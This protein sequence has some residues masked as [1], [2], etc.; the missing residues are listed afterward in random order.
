MNKDLLKFDDMYFN[1]DKIY[2]ITD[3]ERRFRIPRVMFQEICNKIH[4]RKLLV[5]RKDATG[6]PGI[7][8]K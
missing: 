5:E 7:H 1:D 8:R 4:A 3:F 6:K 2:D